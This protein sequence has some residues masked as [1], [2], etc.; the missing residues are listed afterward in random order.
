MKRA[1]IVPAVVVAAVLTASAA[2]AQLAVA[3]AST[4]MQTDGALK[5]P[6][7]VWTSAVAADWV[8]TYQFS[9]RYGDLLH[10]RN[11]VLRALDG[12]P[13]WLVAAGASVDAATGWAVYRL[14]GSRHPRLM[15]AALYG[16]AAYRTYLAIDNVRM[17]REARAIRGT[18]GPVATSP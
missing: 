18:S 14:I 3:P 2:A 7:Y 6:T 10:E 5:I 16:A 15:Q 12:H 8:T 17:M 11:P 4:G 13:A 9:S 1:L